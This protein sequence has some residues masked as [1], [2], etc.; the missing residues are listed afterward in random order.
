MRK[1]AALSLV[2]IALGGGFFGGVWLSRYSSDSIERSRQLRGPEDKADVA[3]RALRL[4]RD[5]GTNAGP[6]LEIQLDD[7]IISLGELVA[8]KPASQRNQL[9]L[10][11]LGAARDYR[12]RFPHKSKRAGVDAEIAQVFAMLDELH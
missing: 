5:G 9:D 12:A 2:A 6:F 10:K 8:S 1:S 3:L 11:L 7:A 4:L